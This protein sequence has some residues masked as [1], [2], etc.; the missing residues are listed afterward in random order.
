MPSYGTVI[1]REALHYHGQFKPSIPNNQPSSTFV[2]DL[3]FYDFILHAKDIKKVFL[4]G[5]CITNN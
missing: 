3:R 4:N 2:D 1:S 5:E